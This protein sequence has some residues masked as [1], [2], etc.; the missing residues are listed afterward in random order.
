M[1]PLNKGWMKEPLGRGVKRKM[2]FV[3]DLQIV[4][5]KYK[6]LTSSRKINSSYLPPECGEPTLGILGTAKLY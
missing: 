4:S 2:S 6:L 3:S 1:I 5:S